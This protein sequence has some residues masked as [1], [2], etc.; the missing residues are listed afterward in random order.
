M[1]NMMSLPLELIVRIVDLAVEDSIALSADY[2]QEITRRQILLRLSLVSK[3]F[4]QPSQRALCKYVTQSDFEM[5]RFVDNLGQDKVIE[6][7]QMDYNRD[8]GGYIGTPELM[9]FLERVLEVKSLIIYTDG[10]ETRVLDLSNVSS[11]QS[12]FSIL[13]SR[14]ETTI[15]V[16]KIS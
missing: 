15:S 10:M 14:S 16:D 11:L 1:A 3:T 5:T 9:S 13:P 8:I 6:E 12:E 4:K 7:A 2:L